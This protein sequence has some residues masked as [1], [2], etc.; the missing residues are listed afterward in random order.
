[1]ELSL[2]TATNNSPTGQKGVMLNITQL[3]EA[4]RLTLARR[5]QANINQ[6]AS[7]GITQSANDALSAVLTEIEAERNL[8]AKPQAKAQPATAKAVAKPANGG[9][10]VPSKL[11]FNC[12][13]V[14]DAVLV[15]E[16]R[17]SS[18]LNWMY[19]GK[20]PTINGVEFNYVNP[21]VRKK[22]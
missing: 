10:N 7:L 2:I 9:Y 15:V 20:F 18:K 5:V 16:F 4:E 21:A 11:T 22:S 14:P 8:V 13:E 3:T 1:M 6:F 12:V 17:E 19:S